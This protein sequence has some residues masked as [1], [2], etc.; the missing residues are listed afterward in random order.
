MTGHGAGRTFAERAVDSGGLCMFERVITPELE[1]SCVDKT[2]EELNNTL[3]SDMVQ[4]RRG[5]CFTVEVVKQHFV[6]G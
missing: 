3:S 2:Y 1:C 5:R 6:C 4:E